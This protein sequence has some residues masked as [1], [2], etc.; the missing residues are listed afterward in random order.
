MTV[1]VKIISLTVDYLAQGLH[2]K[3]DVTPAAFLTTDKL[4]K[5]EGACVY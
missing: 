3:Y 5:Y 2:I 1:F 4:V